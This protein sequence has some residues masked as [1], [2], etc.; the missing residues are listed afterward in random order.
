MFRFYLRSVLLVA[1]VLSADELPDLSGLGRASYADRELAEVDLTDWILQNQKQAR[2]MLLTEYLQ[3]KDPEIRVRMLVLLERAY[4]PPVGYVGIYM[5]SARVGQNGFFQ[6]GN[7]QAGVKISRVAPGTPAEAS[8][9][10]VNDILVEIGDWKVGNGFDVVE[11]VASRIQSNLP[12]AQISL[13][14]KRGDK[15]LRL[16][17]KLG[18][19]PV[20]SAR[21]ASI[22]EADESAGRLLP[23][24]LQGQIKEFRSWLEEEI[25]KDRKN[26][27]AD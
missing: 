24:S 9:L 15:F 21:A 6:P 16:D 23:V 13:G 26:L 27:I 7:E 4:F 19:L 3:A 20:P 8:G 2:Q 12:G 1:G 25:R 14:V 18:V 5:Q 22:R 17:F 10:Q 11:Q